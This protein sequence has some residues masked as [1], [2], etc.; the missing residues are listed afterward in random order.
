MKQVG[1]FG[2]SALI[3]SPPAV[4]R[5]G[6]VTYHAPEVH[7]SLHYSTKSDVW[8]IGVI[9]W[10]TMQLRPSGGEP[11]NLGVVNFALM[12]PVYGLPARELLMMHLAHH[13]DKRPP[14]GALKETMLQLLQESTRHTVASRAYTSSAAAQA[15][16]AQQAEWMRPRTL[17]V[18]GTIADAS[19]HVTSGMEQDQCAETTSSRPQGGGVFVVLDSDTQSGREGAAM[20]SIEHPHAPATQDVN[21]EQTGSMP[22]AGDP[23]PAHNESA[24]EVLEL[25]QELGMYISAGTGGEFGAWKVASL[26]EDKP[27]AKSNSIAAGDY[28]WEINGKVIFGM[29]FQLISS[30]VKGKSLELRLGV[31]KGLGLSIL[32]AVIRRDGIYATGKI[33]ASIISSPQ[34]NPFEGAPVVLPVLGAREEIAESLTLSRP[35]AEAPSVPVFMTVPVSMLHS[36]KISPISSLFV[37]NSA[38]IS[39]MSSPILPML[40]EAASTT[41]S[42]HDV[43]PEQAIFEVETPSKFVKTAAGSAQRSA[44]PPPPAPIA[45]APCAAVAEISDAKTS[46]IQQEPQ[47]IGGMSNPVDRSFTSGQ[48]SGLHDTPVDSSDAQLHSAQL[49]S[50]HAAHAAS[51]PARTRA[52]APLVE[53]NLHSAIGLVST[54]IL[55]MS[56]TARAEVGSA[57]I[58]VEVGSATI[59]GD[60]RYSGELLK[61]KPF[62]MGTASWPH[63]GHTYVGEW[64]N[65]VMHGHGTATYLNGDRYDGEWVNGKRSGLGRYAHG[66]GDIYEGLWSNERK[67]GLGVD[68]FADGRGYRGEFV[69]NKFAGIG[70]YF[71]VDGAVYQV[72]PPTLPPHPFS[73]ILKAHVCRIHHRICKCL[74]TRLWDVTG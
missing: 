1:D 36:A 60:G 72:K 48:S 18:P 34:H 26:P 46:A 6:T 23:D 40:A 31:K 55:D 27:A 45:P 71:T 28:L 70:A 43:W 9:M 44:A 29:P 32:S 50:T 14:C 16:A 2:V 22:E 59:A 38:K 62:G 35:P 30:L 63:Q 21:R 74:L 15:D 3:S 68:S 66:S 20:S 33:D 42:M 56:E 5:I 25:S 19:E 39:P 4:E 8:A 7:S 41:E 17:Q 47:G 61:G 67:H 49:H 37:D 69:E 12:L 54:D 13:P 53:N 52:A 24:P 11:L 57:S 51:A 65:G 73:T 10:E 58:A 64:R